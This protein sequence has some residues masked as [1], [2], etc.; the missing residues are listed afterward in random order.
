M[1]EFS[2]QMTIQV[3]MYRDSFFIWLLIILWTFSQAFLQIIVSS[4]FMCSSR[5]YFLTWSHIWIFILCS[6]DILVM[7]EH[8]AFHFIASQSICLSDQ[9]NCLC[10]SVAIVLSWNYVHWFQFMI[11]I[12]FVSFV[13]KLHK[14]ESY[15]LIHSSCCSQ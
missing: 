5:S 4:N 11:Q 2:F 10:W 3:H 1:N 14:T 13:H 6:C 9:Q 12:Q 8:R 7:S 15:S